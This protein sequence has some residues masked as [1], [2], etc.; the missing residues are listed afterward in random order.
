MRSDR[1]SVGRGPGQVVKSRLGL[2]SSVRSSLVDLGVDGRRA[3]DGKD[4]PE[5]GRG[6]VALE[7]LCSPQSQGGDDFRGAGVGTSV[8]GRVRRLA[9]A[10]LV[11][12][13]LAT[14]G[15]RGVCP[16]RAVPCSAV[17]GVLSVDEGW[18][19]D[20]LDDRCLKIGRGLE[21]NEGRDRDRP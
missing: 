18:M 11:L 4:G 1:A 12:G 17:R 14:E 16:V 13:K 9:P 8:A 19:V 6:V 2:A 3:S 15:A 20:P 7:R 21:E 5:P 10:V